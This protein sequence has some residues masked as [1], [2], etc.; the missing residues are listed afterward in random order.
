MG[1][2][3]GGGVSYRLVTDPDGVTALAGKV[4]EITGLQEAHV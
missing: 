4:A 1:E 2:P 3:D